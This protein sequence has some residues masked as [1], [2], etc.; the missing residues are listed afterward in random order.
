MRGEYVLTAA[1][2]E[3][4]G[5]DHIQHCWIDDAMVVTCSDS[6]LVH[7]FLGLQGLKILAIQE[8]K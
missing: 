6:R 1:V 7:G 5:D 3:G 8:G 2:A 4:L